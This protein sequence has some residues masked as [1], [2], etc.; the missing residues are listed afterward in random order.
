M[1]R[2]QRWN[3]FRDDWNDAAQRSLVG[4]FT[5]PQITALRYQWRI[6]Q[7]SRAALL[8]LP[9]LLL[10]SILAPTLDMVLFW[11]LL[12]WSLGKSL[13]LLA[14]VLL[15]WRYGVSYAWAYHPVRPMLLKGA[16][17]EN[18]LRL[19]AVVAALFA[20]IAFFCLLVTW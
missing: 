18:N 11:G 17:A 13:L 4:R 2:K 10:I 5:R 1:L 8:V 3:W 15:G 14:H 6:G 19:K 12:G 20:T 7:I 16:P 9:A